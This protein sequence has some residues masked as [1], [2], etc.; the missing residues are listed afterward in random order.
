MPTPPPG[1]TESAPEKKQLNPVAET[2][3]IVAAALVFAFLIQWLLVKPYKIPS[4]S[5]VPT[6]ET[7]QRVL[8]NRI[9]GRFGT[10]SR[11]DV[12]VFHPPPGANEQR[13]GIQSGEK[14]GP[15]PG[16]TYVG[17]PDLEDL[18]SQTDDA[19]Y[20]ACPVATAGTQK[21]AFIKRVVGMPGDR[22]KIIKGHAYVNGKMLNEPY[23]NRLQS[24]DDPSNFTLSCTY[25]R[26]FTIPPGKYFMMGDNR[27]N[28]D[29]SRFWGPIPK[30]SMVG[31]AFATYWPINRIG[32]L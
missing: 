26:E 13:C 32:G 7:G 19:S 4:P 8:V 25:S 22:F 18:P 20:M 31:E 2:A 10:P 11:G 1:S 23:I 17:V 14:F 29:D 21:Q 16:Q 24:C 3:V 6:L 9:E 30:S 27:N 28:S 12:V 15:P 5:M